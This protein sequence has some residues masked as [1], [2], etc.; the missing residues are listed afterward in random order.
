[1]RDERKAPAALGDGHHHGHRPG[2]LAS[3][4]VAEEAVA[5]LATAPALPLAADVF[6]APLPHAREIGDE[7]VNGLRGRLDLDTGFTVHAMDG[8]EHSPQ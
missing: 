7:V 5:Y 1:V 4:I 2:T 6:G 8:H 3:P